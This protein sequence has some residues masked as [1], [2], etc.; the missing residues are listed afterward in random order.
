MTTARTPGTYARPNTPVARHSAPAISESFATRAGRV[1]H[2]RPLARVTTRQSAIWVGVLWI[3]ATVFPAASIVPWSGLDDGE[4]ILTNAATH[5]GQLIAWALLNLV[6]AVAAS[7][8]A[9]MFYPV[10]SRVA[11]TSVE[12]GLALWYVGTRIT[13][14]GTYLVAVLA[15]WAFLPLSRE[16]AAAGAPDASHFQTSGALLQSTSDLALTL[17]QSV[18]AIGAVMLYYLLFRSRLVPRWLSLWGLAAAP[19]FLIASLSLLWTGDPNSTLAN[20]L[21]GPLAV[22][23]MV[24]ALWLIVKGFDTAALASR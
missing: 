5:K 16:F 8:V 22:Q 7:G 11:E 13:E 14:G 17:A 21:F 2:P 23:E 4:G 1:S 24:L 19:L 15:T 18:F 20:I 12:R 10:L 3:M 6:G 9:L